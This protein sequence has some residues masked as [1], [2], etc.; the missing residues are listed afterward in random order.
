MS[1][2]LLSATHLNMI[3]LNY[4][5]SLIMVANL[6]TIVISE[7]DLPPQYLSN[8]P[9]YFCTYLKRTAL[10]QFYLEQKCSLRE[11]TRIRPNKGAI[12]N[13]SHIT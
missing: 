2:L 1:F 7:C 8:I 3:F 5:N 13:V 9:I 10:L 4:W 11:Y 12:Q 6:T